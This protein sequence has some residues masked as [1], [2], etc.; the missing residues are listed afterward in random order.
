[1]KPSVKSMTLMGL[2]TAII[3]V[4]GPLSIPLP[5]SPV[6][7]SFTNFALYLA[8]YVLGMRKA[9][10]SF[11]IYLVIGT[12][13]VPVFSGFGSGLAKLLGPTGGYLI[14]FVFLVLIVGFFVERFPKNVAACVGGMVLG[15]AVCYLFGSVWLAIQN[16][17]TPVQAF[18]LG[19]V[20]YLPGDAV[21]IA[22]AA[23][24]GPKLREAARSIMETA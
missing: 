19:V 21:K 4:L 15:L 7:I 14:G 11:L 2:M 5:F 8:A 22:V 17:I 9:T 1:M 6:P 23:I 16:H 12:I 20:P 3:C 24:I 18:L 10:V 13:G